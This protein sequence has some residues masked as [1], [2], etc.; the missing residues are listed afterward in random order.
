MRHG[1]AVTQPGDALSGLDRTA[2]HARQSG[3]GIASAVEGPR[4]APARARFAT[5]SPYSRPR[6]EICRSRAPGPG[7]G[8]AHHRTTH[9]TLAQDGRHALAEEVGP[10][11]I[12]PSA[13]RMRAGLAP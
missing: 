1:V 6:K 2:P 9:G 7:L 8:L 11:F 10:G 5:A 4:P 13:P 3:E 12:G